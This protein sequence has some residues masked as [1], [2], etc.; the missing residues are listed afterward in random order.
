MEIIWQREKVFLKD[1][2]EDYPD[3][4]PAA[5][6]IATLLKRMQD[7]EFVS[8]KMFGNSRQYYSLVKKDSYFSKHLRNLIRNNF[9][10]SAFQFAS[11][12]ATASNLS[13][14]ELEDLRKIVDEQIK[15]KK[16]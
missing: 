9:N 14:S 4:P 3:P 10:N 13:A 12:F 6:T 2:I 1:I 8:Y 15:K 5:T 16:K 11:F 7:K